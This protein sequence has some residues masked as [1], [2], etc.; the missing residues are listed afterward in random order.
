VVRET[1]RAWLGW[2]RDVLLLQL[3][4]G[5]RVARL[6][7]GGRAALQATADQVGLTAARS[8]TASLQQALAD[9]DTNVNARLV[10]DLLVLRLPGARLA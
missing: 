10:L 5:E 3:G 1:L 9:L 8:A 2:W 4:H 7:R 6:E